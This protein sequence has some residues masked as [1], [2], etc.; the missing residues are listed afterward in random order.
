MVGIVTASARNMQAAVDGLREEV[1]AQ[2]NQN[3]VDLERKQ[4]ETQGTVK[5]IAADLKEF[6]RQL[7]SFKPASESALGECRVKFL[8]KYPTDYLLQSKK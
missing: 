2:M 3:R 5:K 4:M 7:I 1:K 8:Q 6:T